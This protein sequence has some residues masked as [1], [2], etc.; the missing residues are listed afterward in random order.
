MSHRGP[1]SE[2][3]LV[4]GPVGPRGEA[5]LDHRPGAWRPADRATRIAPSRSSRTARS[6]TTGSCEPSSERAATG[7]RPAATRRSSCTSTRSGGRS[8][9]SAL[10]GMFAIALWD[11]ARR[12]LVLARD[13]FGIK[14][15][16][17]RLAGAH[18]L[19]R[20][21]ARRRS[22]RQPGFERAIDLDA[23]EA[24]LAFNSIPAPLT[25]FAEVR[26]LP[27]GHVLVW[28]GERASGRAATRGRARCGA[29]DCAR[30]RGTSS[31]P[32]SFATGCATPSG[33]TWWP[34]C[35]SGV[36]LSG[37]RRLVGAHRA[38]RQRELGRR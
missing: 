20:L 36:L 19:L 37:G 21:G 29:G 26:K 24:F 33:R 8:S 6:T 13:P 3:M 14:P 11:S 9:W 4:D 10:R 15:L 25:I 34:M 32:R 23:V 18:A 1:D 38:R 12:R 31:S 7:S 27:A 5:A 35:Q 30:S 2:G 16:Y 17:Y 28:D 22:L